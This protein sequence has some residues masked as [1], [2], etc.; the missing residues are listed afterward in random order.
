MRIF[1]S[2][3]L[4]SFHLHAACE[5]Q[6]SAKKVISLSGSSTVVFQE[7]GLLSKLYGISVF[8]PITDFKG[9]VY[10][11][12][13]FFSHGSLSELENSVVFYDES[14]DLKKVL[15]SRKN[16]KALE[17]RTRNLTPRE[18][19]D[20]TVKAISPFIQHCEEEIKK[21]S[22][23]VSALEEKL[24]KKIPKGL[25]VVFY[26]GEFRQNQTPEFVI[27][28]DG[29]V[30][31]LKDKGRIKTYPSEL[32]YVNWSSKLLNEMPA[33]T[34]HV[35]IKDPGRESKREIKRSSRRMTLIYP[36]SLVP[37]LTQL[38]AFVYWAESI[39]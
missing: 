35:G 23:K 22:E 7:L 12:G 18:T 10:P 17:I 26:L 1:L 13:I 30:K 29:V 32:A 25:N 5:F 28:N 34:I 16:V 36:G 20:I 19:V 31:W 27:A 8:N 4:L 2:L 15:E 3:F 39:F 9:K 14:R 37:G 6:A 11:G 38:E 21:L 33:N 24:L